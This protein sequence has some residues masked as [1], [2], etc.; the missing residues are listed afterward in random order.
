M[1]RIIGAFILV[2]LLSGCGPSAGDGWLPVA[3]RACVKVGGGSGTAIRTADGKSL[4]LTA[5]H[6]IPNSEKYVIVTVYGYDQRG[7]VDSVR[8]LPAKILI[9]EPFTDTALVEVETTIQP[10]CIIAPYRLLTPGETLWSVGLPYVITPMVQR[11]VFAGRIM[12]GLSLSPL[13]S[14]GAVPGCSGSAVYDDYGCIR[15]VLTS[16]P[17]RP[18]T[19]KDGMLFRIDYFHHMNIFAEVSDQWIEMLLYA[20]K[21]RDEEKSNEHKSDSGRTSPSTQ[22]AIDGITPGLDG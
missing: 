14:G 5:A 10:G 3:L 20:A 22:P 11:G 8:H 9:A 17:G 19:S 7:L 2:Y 18:V 12:R 16:R 13:F 1:K 4:I 6:L 21:L 15:G